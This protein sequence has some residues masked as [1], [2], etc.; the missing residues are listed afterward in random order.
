RKVACELT[1]EMIDST[2]GQ[3]M[4]E[5]VPQL[6]RADRNRVGTGKGARREL[7]C[8]RRPYGDDV[9]LRTRGVE[10][11]PQLANDLDAAVTDLIEVIDRCDDTA[12][13]RFRREQRLRG[14][15]DEQTRDPYPVVG[16][17]TDATG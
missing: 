9:T 15:E 11:R 1:Q 12:C 10:G 4:H 14:V 13:A 6:A 2:V 7:H 3:R 16:Q 5:Q 17:P 8:R